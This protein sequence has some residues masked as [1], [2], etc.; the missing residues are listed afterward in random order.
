[1]NL[2]QT[3]IA[4]DDDKRKAIAIDSEFLSLT[5]KVAKRF[6]I[7]VFFILT[8]MAFFAYEEENKTWVLVWLLLS[9]TM[10][11]GRIAG[12]KKII[13]N[14]DINDKQKI[15]W[16]CLLNAGNGICLGLSLSFFPY[17]SAIERVFQSLLFTG[18]CASVVASNFGLIRAILPY[19]LFTLIPLA[20]VWVVFADND[21]ALWKFYLFALTILLYIPILISIA[22]GYFGFFESSVEMRLKNTAINKQ[23]EKALNE[24]KASNAAKTRFLATASHDLRQPVHTLSLLTAAL[25]SRQLE[26]KTAI[27]VWVR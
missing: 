16:I 1:M 22:R 21:E 24:S 8:V 11:F 10:L 5:A 13:A 17:L 23:L 12:I 3:V 4:E 20:I 26:P 7:P 18:I 19:L 2:N 25:M 14:T 15:N 9:S 27:S 6:P